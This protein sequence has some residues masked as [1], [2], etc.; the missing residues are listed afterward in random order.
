MSYQLNVSARSETEDTPADRVSSDGDEEDD[1]EENWDDWVSDSATTQPC[2]SLF[3]EKTLPSVEDALRHDKTVH[4]FDLDYICSNLSLDIHGRIRLINFIR[5]NKIS[6]DVARDFIGTEPFFSSDEYLIPILEDD[7]LLQFQP[8]WSDSEDENVDPQKRIR[9][10]QRQ[11]ATAKQDLVEYRNLVTREVDITRLLE[12]LDTE[13]QEGA[14]KVARDDD[15]YYF[16]SYQENDIHAIMIQD[17]VRTSTYAHFILT[18]PS[19]FRDAVVLDVG[20]GTGILSLFA[21]RAGA[22]RVIAVDASDVADRAKYVV[23][24][25]GLEDIITVIKGRVEDISLPDGIEKVDIIVSEWM[26]Y[27]LLYESM[28]DS[29]LHARDQFLKPEGLMAPSQCRMLLALCDA[30]DVYKERIT[31]WSDVY[32]F[33][34]S[35]MAESAFGEAAID[36]VGPE[37]LLGEPCIVKDFVLKDVHSRHLNFSSDFTLISTIGKRSKVNTFVL[38][39]DTFFSPTGQSLSQNTPAHTLKEGDVALAELWPVGG[40]PASKRRQSLGKEKVN[41]SS[42]STGPRSVPTHWKQ[43]LFLLRE[44]FSVVEG[45]VVSGTF[46]CRKSDKNS[47]ELDIEIHYSVQKD[48]ETPSNQLHVQL[49]KVR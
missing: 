5:K 11:L 33:D 36:V 34:M 43:T 37:S 15:D 20:C 16:Q 45:S 21:A 35:I 10:L 46:H 9:S 25:N 41:T 40:K 7:P 12:A 2:R 32:G 48:T 14:T 49:F 47:R 28:L 8:Q 19:L 30:S 44:P 27:A 22:K 6:P 24:A 23:Q 42:F 18:N 26:G 38:Y 13:K 39:F 29:V 17:K 4:T 3:D 31:S 1:E